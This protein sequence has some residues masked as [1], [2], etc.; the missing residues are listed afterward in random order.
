MTPKLT[1]GMAT[2]LDYDGVYFTVQALRLNNLIGFEAGEVEVLVVDNGPEGKISAALVKFLE[3]V[4]GSRYIPFREVTGTAAARDRV[5]AEAQG[6]VV[7]C[8]DCHVLFAGT[9]LPVYE[10]ARDHQQDLV[11]GPMISDPLNFSDASTHWAGGW[12]NQ[13]Y[14]SWATDAR[15]AGTEAFEIDMTGL[16]AFAMWRISWPG[17]H[18]SFQGFGGE[19]GYIHSKVRKQGGRCWCLPSFLW[20]HRF[21]RP[22]GVPYRNTAEDRIRNYLIGW[23]ELGWD[24]TDMLEHFRAECGHEVVDDVL[25]RYLNDYP[26][27]AHCL[28]IPLDCPNPTVCQSE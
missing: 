11:Q 25:K 10:F 15:V 12:K 20:L 4:P 9:L 23:R 27:I 5:F 3:D 17:F 19:E 21:G 2:Y 8:C 28:T 6:D 7:L 24:T 13:M 26:E 1:V 16:G 14:G 18:P 22:G